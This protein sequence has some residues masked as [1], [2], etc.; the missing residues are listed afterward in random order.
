MKRALSHAPQRRWLRVFVAHERERGCVRFFFRVIAKVS[1]LVI[2]WNSERYEF[3]HISE[4][5]HMVFP[6]LL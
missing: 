2:A 5:A 6:T 1:S 3:N 4:K